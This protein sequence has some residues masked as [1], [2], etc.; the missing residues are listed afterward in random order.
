MDHG[1]TGEA[2]LRGVRETLDH[3][4]VMGA[5]GGLVAGAVA[6]SLAALLAD[7]VGSPAS[8]VRLVAASLLGP[9][10]LDHGSTFPAYLGALL[11]GVFAVVFAL[12]LLCLMPEGAGPV[13]ATA[14]GA[15]FG[16]VLFFPVWFALVRVAD[17]LLFEAS[18]GYGPLVLGLHAVYGAI[19]GFLAPILRRTVL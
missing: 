4:L 16:V 19:L 17:P 13:P 15:A 3:D 6:W 8:P 11:A 18:R 2:R 14:A 9:A 12:P 1:P 10:A 7:V 5:V